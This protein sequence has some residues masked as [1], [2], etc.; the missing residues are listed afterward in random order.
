MYFESESTAEKKSLVN[1][2]PTLLG[3]E[4]MKISTGSQHK[5]VRSAIAVITSLLSYH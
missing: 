1:I 4:M 2:S 5:I 3:Y